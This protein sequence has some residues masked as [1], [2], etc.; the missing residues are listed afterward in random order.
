MT[1]SGS[2]GDGWVWSTLGWLAFPLVPALL[3]TVYQGTLNLNYP[4]ST[5]GPEPRDWD[6]VRWVILM[7]PLAGYGFLAG[8]TLSLPEEPT[9]R[10]WWSWLG[11]RATWVGVGP[12]VGFLAWAAL[13]LTIW[14]IGWVAVRVYPPSQDWEPTGGQPI[15]HVLDQTWAGWLFGRALMI[16][17][18]G[19]LSYGW[20]GL[21]WRVIRREGRSGRARRALGRGLAVA[22]GFVGSLIGTFWA[23]TSAC[24]GFF[25]DPRIMPALLA[26]GS[27]FFLSGCANTL[28]YGEVRRRD[29]FQAMLTAWL[30]G[31]ALLWRWWSR[32]RRPGTPG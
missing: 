11:R 15:F 25:F 26:A 20:L 31:L 12:W 3:G 14:A 19:T 28:S 2:R 6:W 18:I 7:G 10:G 5:H 17:A 21:A 8:A 9:Q 30:L 29:L 16:V 4:S 27:T 23:V 13:L 32:P 24:R 22:L 1:N